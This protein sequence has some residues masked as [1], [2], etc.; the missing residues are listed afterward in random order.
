MRFTSIIILSVL[1]FNIISCI[2]YSNKNV[3]AERPAV[4]RYMNLNAV[5][6]SLHVKNKEAI[7]NKRVKMRLEKLLKDAREKLLYGK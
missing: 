5:Y 2:P 3:K 1:S 7:E 6:T 4:I